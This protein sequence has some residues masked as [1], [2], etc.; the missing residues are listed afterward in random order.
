MANQKGIV[1]RVMKVLG[2]VPLGDTVEVTDGGM[3]DRFLKYHAANRDKRFF[4][5]VAGFAGY[6]TVY[7]K[8]KDEAVEE[9]TK[10]EEHLFP[11]KD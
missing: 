3:F 4:E 5:A 8:R 2:W 9:L 6:V 10:I 7:G 1:E 11:N